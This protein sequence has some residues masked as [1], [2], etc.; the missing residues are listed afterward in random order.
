MPTLHRPRIQTCTFFLLILVAIAG[1][2]RTTPVETQANLATYVGRAACAQCHVAEAKAWSGSDHAR[3]MAPASTSSVLGDFNNIRFTYNRITTTFFRKGEEYWVRTDGPDGKLADYRARYTFGVDPLQQYLIEFPDGRMQALDI[4]WDSRPRAAGGQRW[5]HLHPRDKVDYRDV[6]HWTGPA[7]NWN[8]M[9][10]ECHS[11]DLRKNYRASEEHFKTSWKE[12][13]VSCEACHGPGSRHVAWAK[14]GRSAPDPMKGLEA[15]LSRGKGEWVLRGTSPIAV[16]TEKR[17]TAAQVETCARCHSRRTQINEDW[18][19]GQPIAQTHRVSLL[20]EELYYADGQI[21]D[22]V[23]EYG[24]FLQSS[25]HTSGVAC[26][27]CHDPHSARLKAEGNA[28][29]TPCHQPAVF[30]TPAH[31]RHR[32]GGEAARCVSC[33][34]TARTYM[35]VDPRRDHSFRVPRPDLSVQLG[36]PNACNGCHQNRSPSWAAA[37]IVK[38]HGP[39]RLRGAGWAAAIAAGRQWQAGG[40]KLLAAAASSTANPPVIRATA[41]ELLARFPQAVRPELLEASL[42]DPDPFLRRAALGLLFTVEPAKRWALGSPLL[43]DAIRT[44]RLE[45]VSALADVPA[46]IS[47]PS[48]QR[49]SFDRAVEEYRAAQAL[50]ADRAD[51]WL[52]VGALEA[53]LGN[54]GQ[55]EAAYQH[56]IRLQ[57]SFMPS[58]VNLADLYRTQAREEDAE[59]VLREA[60][61]RQ[62]DTADIHHALGL[63]LVRRKQVAEAVR[64]LSR[65]SELAPDAPRYAYVHAL[66]LDRMGRHT[67]ALAVLA[68]AHRR[69]TGDRDI[70]GALIE[71]SLQ[72]GDRQAATRWAQKLRDLDDPGR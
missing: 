45:A 52:N 64:E 51:A 24:S 36:T 46:A 67:E 20:D 50:N 62:P 65:A 41:L 29:C 28:L 44:V 25:M 3:A 68:K 9:C 4:A 42:R 32:E 60:L 15:R 70:L 19:A 16:L 43:A 27:D 34:M 1:C 72:A 56:A 55:A 40:D 37:T 39:E 22:E 6:L 54:T 66:A 69:F 10:A 12:I 14:G 2:Q 23:Y 71:L 11:T 8:H 5:F 21:L 59:R 61:A 31:H 30:D 47:I 49:G 26:S 18:R 7:L 17:A 63:L 35:V 38:W 58:Y 53:R 33:H 57:P 48:G 13:E